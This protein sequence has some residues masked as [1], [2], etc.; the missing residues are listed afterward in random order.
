M[1]SKS[2]GT[3]P[4]RNGGDRSES[5][6]LFFGLIGTLPVYF[7]NKREVSLFKFVTCVYQ[8][9]RR[10]EFLT[11]VR[12]S[13][14]VTFV[15]MLGTLKGEFESAL[16]VNWNVS[17]PR[18]VIITSSFLAVSRTSESFCR[19]CEYVYRLISFTPISK[20][21]ALWQLVS[22]VYQG[23]ELERASSMRSPGSTRRRHRC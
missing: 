12:M 15:L 5:A 21:Q 23:S 19:A 16:S 13:R 20:C 14:V 2:C 22:F 7:G 3:P 6:G 18:L 4:S 11:A 17:P 8:D 10:R 9:F 1:N